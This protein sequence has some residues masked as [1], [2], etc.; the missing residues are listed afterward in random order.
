[1]I[2]EERV[3]WVTEPQGPEALSAVIREISRDTATVR[4]MQDHA[5]EV[6]DDKYTFD[7]ALGKFMVMFAKVSE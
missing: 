3:G 5:R 6:A 1:M 4:A 2:D 7:H